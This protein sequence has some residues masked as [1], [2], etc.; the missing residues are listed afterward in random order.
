M[1]DDE[2]VYGDFQHQRIEGDEIERANIGEGRS[3]MDEYQLVRKTKTEVGI[4]QTRD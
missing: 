4:G 3:W 1:S 2:E